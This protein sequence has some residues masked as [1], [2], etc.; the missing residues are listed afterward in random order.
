VITDLDDLNR[1]LQPGDTCAST[2]NGTPITWWRT[3]WSTTPVDVYVYV[4]VTHETGT[5]SRVKLASAP[6]L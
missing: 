4:D 5:A 6:P 3:R 2:L 1:Q